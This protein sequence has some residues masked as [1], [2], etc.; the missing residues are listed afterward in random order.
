M[1]DDFAAILECLQKLEGVD[2]LQVIGIAN[3]LYQ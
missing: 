2:I 3:E 1:S